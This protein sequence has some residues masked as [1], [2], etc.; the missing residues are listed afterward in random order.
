[1]S[2]HPSKQ[3]CMN[4]MAIQHCGSNCVEI[5]QLFPPPLSAHNGTLGKPLRPL[6]F[7]MIFQ[8]QLCNRKR[9]YALSS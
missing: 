6:D 4:D 8:L 2:A 7:E 5:G 1:M 3:N 9:C